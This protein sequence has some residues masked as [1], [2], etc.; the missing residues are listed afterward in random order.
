MPIDQTLAFGWRPD[1]PD[2][3]DYSP[4]SNQK[5]GI[6]DHVASECDAAVS[7]SQEWSLDRPGHACLIEDE[8]QP[9]RIDCPGRSFSCASVVLSLADW[10]SRRELGKAL[11]RSPRFL[12]HATVQIYRAS[13]D[14]VSL[15]QTLKAVARFGA[16]PR[17]L[18]D[19]SADMD[20]A[21][22][23]VGPESLK[24]SHSWHFAYAREFELMRYYRLDLGG[25][26]SDRSL[27]RIKWWIDRG[28]PCLFG[29]SV[30]ESVSLAPLIPFDPRRNGILGGTAAIVVGY[31]DSFDG[32][33]TRG[34]SEV[35]AAGALRIRTCWGSD[36]GEHG[37]GW[38]PYEYVR[39]RLAADFWGVTL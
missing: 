29:F 24:A 7:L 21:C 36:W 30:P 20:C 37:F 27:Q 13:P 15:R 22:V 32:T 38:L 16:P 31:D 4:L 18:V 14:H 17:R 35:R 5:S 28:H 25:D 33:A 26:D 2:G 8:L 9:R 12:H 11:D 39:T 1:L 19:R 6:S 34:V 3:R 10:V 23:S